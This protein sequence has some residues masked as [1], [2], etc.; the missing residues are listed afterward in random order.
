MNQIIYALAL[1]TLMTPMVVSAQDLPGLDKSP[2]D[3]A[4]FRKGD[5]PMVKVIYSR[6]LRNG[7]T[8]FGDVVKYGD[9]WRTGANE[10][11]E[12]RFYQDVTFGGKSVKAGT[13]SLFTIPG[14][15]TWTVI[16]SSDL[17]IWG[18]YRYNKTKDVV[19][20]DVPAGKTASAVEAFTIAFKKEDGNARM[21]LAWDAVMVEVPVV[22]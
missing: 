4:Y 18:A 5:S 19:R 11:T 16:L 20:V 10:A 15:Q 3:I 2:A 8:I 17:D 21:I 7:R 13:Y 6:P 22:F 14:E 9:V 12:I 1:V